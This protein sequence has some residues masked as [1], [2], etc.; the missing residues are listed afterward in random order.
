MAKY[1]DLMKWALK[2]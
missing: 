2:G 1:S